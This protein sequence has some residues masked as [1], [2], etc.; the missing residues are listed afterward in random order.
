[1]SNFAAAILIIAAVVVLVLS[2]AGAISK[3]AEIDQ[4]S[5]DRH[6]PAE[7]RAEIVRAW[8]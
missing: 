3:Q 2:A 7:Q 8:K 4:A 5:L 1:M 6:L